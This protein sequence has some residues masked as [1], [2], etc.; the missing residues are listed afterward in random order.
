MRSFTSPILSAATEF[1]LEHR[2]PKGVECPRCGSRNVL[3]LQKY[4]RWHCRAKHKAP[5]FTLKT[6]TVMENS[7][8]ELKKWLAAFWFAAIYKGGGSRLL[9]GMIDVTQKTAWLMLRRIG[10][11]MEPEAPKATRDALLVLLRALEALEEEGQAQLK[12]VGDRLKDPQTR[13]FP[14]ILNL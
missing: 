9:S 13:I 6:G 10:A 14:A 7:P 1:L 11:A 5:Q 4:Q 12:P 8:I 2:W 3:F